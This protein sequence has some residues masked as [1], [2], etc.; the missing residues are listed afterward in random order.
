[1]ILYVHREPLFPS[2]ALANALGRP[3][4][5]QDVL[6][7]AVVTR[8]LVNETGLSGPPR[9]WMFA[10][11]E[12]YLDAPGDLHPHVMGSSDA[13]TGLFHFAVRLHP[14]DRALARP[15]WALI[16]RRLTHVAGFTPA[17]EDAPGCHWVALQARHG[18]LDV[19]ANLI[20]S[21]G[22][23]APD[24]SSLYRALDAECR[25]IEADLGLTAVP[26][27]TTVHRAHTDASPFQL[28]K[29]P[30]PTAPQSPPSVA[31]HIATTMCAL[32]NEDKGPI[33]GVRAL[34]EQA[35]RRLEELPHAYG[36]DAAQHLEWI[37]RRLHGVQQ[38]LETVAAALPGA[39][40]RAALATRRPA[41]PRPIPAR[42]SR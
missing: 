8:S 34:V 20:R 35:A 42:R 18:R 24:G 15:E 33:A 36:P 40:E 38:D 9:S 6:G 17:A 5:E 2:Q 7:D 21:D 22:S 13:V 29:L 23:W 14:A 10:D 11:W 27:R 30:K 16:A 26:T 37:A 19:I 1:M 4:A 41:A 12:D 39:N 31:A 32:A 28:P 3:I 25:R